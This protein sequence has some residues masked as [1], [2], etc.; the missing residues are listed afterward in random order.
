[1]AN[2][3]AAIWFY[4]R[5]PFDNVTKSNFKRMVQLSRD[6]HDKLFKQSGDL[7]IQPLYNLLLPQYV[8]FNKLYAQ[9]QNN[10]ALYQASTLSVENLFAELNRKI[11]RWEAWILTE[12]DD[13]SPEYLSLLP[14]YKAPFQSGPYDIRLQMLAAFEMGLAAYPQLGNVLL[15][16]QQFRINIEATRTKQQGFE[17]NDAELRQ[18]LEGARI[19]L[20][21]A[22]HRILGGLIQLYAHNTAHI[23]T[24]FELRYLQAPT[25]KNNS[26]NPMLTVSGNSRSVAIETKFNDN[27]TIQLSNTGKV[28]LGFFITNNENA[29]TPNDLT[30]LSPN[31]SQT[32]S[33]P[34]LSDGLPEPRFLMV[35]NLNSE[36][37]KYQ[38]EIGT[39]EA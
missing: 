27:N 22:M 21:V 4:L 13:S 35:V 20:A 10:W 3:L 15:D 36:I 33:L 5:N 25:P 39:E 30:L 24:F 16:V 26:N 28:T 7:D 37:G 31:E 14:N 34:D 1:M 29:A 38:F 11:K 12:F 23:E 8:S 19:D 6:L 17:Q 9:V 2:V 18:S 32:Y